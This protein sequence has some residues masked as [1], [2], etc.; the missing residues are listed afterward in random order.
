MSTESIVN[1]QPRGWALEA[2]E[3]AFPQRVF[4]SIENL[5]TT[6]WSWIC[7]CEQ[8]PQRCADG[9]ERFLPL[10]EDAVAPNGLAFHRLPNHV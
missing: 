4:A 1:R 6:C 10:G 9:F 7:P 5:Q 2:E 8:Q 3:G